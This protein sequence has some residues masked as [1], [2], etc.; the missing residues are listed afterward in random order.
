MLIFKSIFLNL[1]EQFSHHYYLHLVINLVVSRELPL[2]CGFLQINRFL[3]ILLKSE[4]NADNR[5][6]TLRDEE[7]KTKK[8]LMHYAAELDFLHVT[9]T[10]AK[11]CPGLLHLK[12]K[13]QLKSGKK[14]G[15]P[16]L[17]I[18]LALTMENDDVAACLIRMMWH[19]R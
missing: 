14:Q 7:D 10:L 16:L 15:L 5:Y 19:E 1:K 6:E 12:T 18:E 3:E 8:T 17:P 9:K 11:K 4:L 13:V 2:T